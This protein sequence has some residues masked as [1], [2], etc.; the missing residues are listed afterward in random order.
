MLYED[1][2]AAI[3]LCKN[4]QSHGKSKHIDIRYHFIREQVSTGTI[5]VKYCRTNDM[6]A[7]MVTK[8]LG[9][10]KFHKLRRLAGVRL[11]VRSVRK[12]TYLSDC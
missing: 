5:E 3:C 1:N 9:K 6:N 4:S 11:K 8:G 12:Y 2:Q 7:D 10:K